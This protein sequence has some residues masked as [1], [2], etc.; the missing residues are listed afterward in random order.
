MTQG[1]LANTKTDRHGFVATVN[2]WLLSA[3]DR[4][5]K[6]PFPGD[7]TIVISLNDGVTQM[8]G[9]TMRSLKLLVEAN[10]YVSAILMVAVSI[11]SVTGNYSLFEFNEELYGPMANNLRIML[12]Y[13]A[14]AEIGICG[15]GLMTKKYRVFIAVGFFLILSIGSLKFY[16]AINDI[17]VDDNFFVFFLY[18]GLSHIVFGIVSG[19]DIINDIQG[20][21]KSGKRPD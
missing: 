17:T 13:L 9:V 18:T 11:M 20:I 4:C 12:I 8:N 5:K 3:A 21:K 6:S 2:L 1:H 19:I 16:G 15:Y 7:Q 14:V 10:F